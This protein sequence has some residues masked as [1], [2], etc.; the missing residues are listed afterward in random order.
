MS[1]V[2]TKLSLDRVEHR[3]ASDRRVGAATMVLGTLWLNNSD[4]SS[5]H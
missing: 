1:A 3:A 4:R 2:R 5:R